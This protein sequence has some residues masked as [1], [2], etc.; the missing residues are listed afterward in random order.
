MHAFTIQVMCSGLCMLNKDPGGLLFLVLIN[1]HFEQGNDEIRTQ[2]KKV[3]S[4]CKLTGAKDVCICDLFAHNIQ[5]V[6]DFSQDGRR[7]VLK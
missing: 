2:C 1:S 4:Q 3:K 7:N 5:F 6:A